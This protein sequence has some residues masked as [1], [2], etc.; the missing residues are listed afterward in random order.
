MKVVF[1]WCMREFWQVEG[2]MEGMEEASDGEG[3]GYPGEMASYLS[4]LSLGG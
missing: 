2:E 1:S 3:R 4:S